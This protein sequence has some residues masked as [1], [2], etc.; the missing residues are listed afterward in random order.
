MSIDGRV[1]PG[2]D[3]PAAV[4]RITRRMA[5]SLRRKN[6]IMSRLPLVW[7]IFRSFNQTRTDGIHANIMGFFC[8]RF[9]IPNPMIEKI[10]LLTDPVFTGHP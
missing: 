4:V 9:R 2:R 7:P 6:G 8:G 1:I 10:P 5:E 3:D